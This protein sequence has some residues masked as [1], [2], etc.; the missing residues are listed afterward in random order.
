MILASASGLSV[1][2]GDS[3]YDTITFAIE[4]N[5]VAREGIYVPWRLAMGSA[6]LGSDTSYSANSY[7]SGSAYVRAGESVAEVKVFP[8]GDIFPERDESF[9]LELLPSQ[10]TGVKGG[11]LT[12]QST[13]WSLDDDGTSKPMSMHVSEP[14]VLEGDAGFKRVEYQ[15]S[16]S[17]P[18]DKAYTVDYNF[19]GSAMAGDHGA[20]AG[21]VTFFKGQSEATVAVRIKGDRAPEGLEYLDMKI[22]TP[23]GIHQASGGQATIID[24]DSNNSSPFVTIA[25]ARVAEG[26]SSYGTL[27]YSV[28]LSKP[29]SQ[30]VYV[31]WRL[32]DGTAT[33]GEDTDYFSGSYASGTVSFNPGDIQKTIEVFP[34]G[35][36]D[37]EL[38]ESFVV[39]I[40]SPDGAQ[41]PGGT[42]TQQAIGW[43]LDDDGLSNSRALQVSDVF[44][45]EGA[46]GS[47]TAS[48]RLEMSRPAD[49][50]LKIGFNTV[51]GSAK[52]GSDFAYKS[53]AVWIMA[54]QTSATIGLDIFGDIIKER[55]E[56]FGLRFNLPNTIRK[57]E[58]GMVTILDDD[59]VNTPNKEVGGAKRDVMKGTGN[60]DVFDGKGGNDVLTGY[61]NADKLSGGRGND[62]LSGGVGKDLLRGGTGN[63]K[64]SGGLKNDRLFGDQGNDRLMGDGGH[65]KLTGGP[66]R[67]ILRGGP[68]F[69]DFI[70][71]GKFG[72]DRIVDFNA[73][74]GKEDIDL[75][76]VRSIKSFRDLKEDHMTKVG[77]HVKIDAGNGNTIMVEGVNLGQLDPSDFLF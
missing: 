70:F 56:S 50:H 46:K 58:G 18:A 40:L 31:P 55:E 65:D 54:G 13:A 17:R 53:G 4:L 8:S 2:E 32:G 12:S 26:D 60:P 74:S 57:V 35:D 24:N 68:G 45:K 72:K 15:L 27:T 9:V 43:V 37:G 42:T 67:D 66:G 7:F 22:K 76:D 14:I 16:L 38:D 44:V 71:A 30:T 75:S 5:E 69:D 63:D 48:V 33:L 23:D 73:R 61:G 28:M 21:K 47:S 3:Y 1:V 25:D 77:K 41:L 49:Q 20:S 6:V 52:A 51:N 64:L 59:K 19:A 34:S 11:G 39:E 36:Y 10:F 62:K 29:S